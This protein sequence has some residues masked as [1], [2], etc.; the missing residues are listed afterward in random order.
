MEK[1]R[2]YIAALHGVA[3]SVF[4]I[5]VSSILS[6]GEWFVKAISEWEGFP[7]VGNLA[8]DNN[9][10]STCLHLLQ[11]ELGHGRPGG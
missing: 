2:M 10:L 8:P 5:L 4:Y 1:E 6:L 11:G 9:F 3:I 7:V